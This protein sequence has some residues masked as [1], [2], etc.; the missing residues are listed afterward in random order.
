MI[1]QTTNLIKY[2]ENYKMSAI[3]LKCPKL[4][5]ISAP[6]LFMLKNSFEDKYV[7]TVSQRNLPS[8]KTRQNKGFDENAKAG[9]F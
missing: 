6:S 3:I 2:F 9:P 1:M 5:T 8:L 7:N 4:M